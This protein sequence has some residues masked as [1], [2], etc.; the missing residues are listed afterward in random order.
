[1]VKIKECEVKL[2]ALV[3]KQNKDNK[4]PRT[5]YPYLKY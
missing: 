1:M 4:F 2:I 3:G 5:P